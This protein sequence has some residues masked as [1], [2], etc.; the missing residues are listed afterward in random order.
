MC[1]HS[2]R[3]RSCSGQKAASDAL[4]LNLEPLV[5]YRSEPE[6]MLFTAGPCEA[7]VCLGYL[8]QEDR[9]RLP[10]AASF[11][12]QAAPGRVWKIAKH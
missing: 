4:E 2:V 9:A 5:S 3:V 12:M 11:P 10:L 1:K 7:Q 6:F 8:E